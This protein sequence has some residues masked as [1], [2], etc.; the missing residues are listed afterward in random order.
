MRSTPS[1]YR[2]TGNRLIMHRRSEKRTT[3]LS[4]CGRTL[5]PFP[6]REGEYVTLYH[7]GVD[8]ATRHVDHVAHGRAVGLAGDPIAGHRHRLHLLAGGVR[9]GGEGI[10]GL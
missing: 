6:A 9:G 4:R 10:A 3:E 8:E 5:A 1:R 7:D 2:C